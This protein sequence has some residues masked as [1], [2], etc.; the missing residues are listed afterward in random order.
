MFL[1]GS[2]GLRVIGIPAVVR[3]LLRPRVK[4]ALRW[5]LSVFVVI[6]V[7]LYLAVTIVPKGI[8]E[9]Y[10]NGVWFYSNDFKNIR[11]ERYGARLRARC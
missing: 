9:G 2:F 5:L 3:E 11:P 7:M 4:T 1:A 8:P 6:G 10:N